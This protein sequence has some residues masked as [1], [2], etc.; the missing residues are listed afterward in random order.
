M[1]FNLGNALVDA[2]KHEAALPHFGRALELEP[3]LLE[4]AL[5][6][7]DA[8]L[9]LHRY[10]DALISFRHAETM[11][12]DDVRVY[13]GIGQSLSEL[14]RPE[15]AE[16]MFRHA[17]QL[18][19]GNVHANFK[20]ALT[21]GHLF[22]FDESIDL[23]RRTIALAPDL[24]PLHNNLGFNLTCAGRYDE[25][26]ASFRRALELQPGLP[27][28]R[29]MLGMSAL[30]RGHWREGWELYDARRANGVQDGYPLFDI[31]DWRGE[32]LD[33]KRFLL[34]REQGAGDE[35][36][37]VRYATVLRGL[38]AAT[39]DLWTRPELVSLMSRA[40]G[41]DRA[42]PEQPR[43]G[44]DFFCPVMSVPRFLPDTSIPN[45]VP[46]LHADASL[47]SQWRER[48]GQIAGARRKVGLVWAG[49]PEHHL[50]R[51]RSVPFDALL[52]L[53]S[54]EGIEW[55]SLQK[56]AEAHKAER[57]DWR[58][59]SLGASL[60]SFDA[61][62]AVIEALDMVIAV[63]TSV[64]HLAGALGQRVGIMVPAQADWRW[65]TDRTDNL[66]YPTARLFRQKTLSDWTPVVKELAQALKQ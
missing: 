12:P 48:I 29:K 55:F 27:V 44:Y 32:P 8:C 34:T 41:I 31:P 58:I 61:T 13:L 5:S 3:S 54:L 21:L 65:S 60:D 50:D 53:A 35:M 47:V 40:D 2:G 36:Q 33:G 14:D 64:A 25:A 39:V 23:Y 30:R 11:N 26:D 28:A 10:D 49:N 17:V 22:R 4:A 15:E 19:P 59:H 42:F 52:P 62:A 43:S 38:G 18:E 45:A 20:L 51:F 46:Y 6:I 7:G 56:G 1:R 37:F 9:H 16:A 63:D 66:W 24:S 57:D